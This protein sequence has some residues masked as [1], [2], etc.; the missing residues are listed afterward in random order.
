MLSS[1]SPARAERVLRMAIATAIC[2]IPVVGC[3][4][5]GCSGGGEKFDV[6]FTPCAADAGTDADG[7]ACP[8]TCLEACRDLEPSSMVGLE[9]ICADSDAAMVALTPGIQVTVHCEAVKN[10]TGRKLDGIAAPL[11]PGEPPGAWLARAAWLEAS[12]IFAFRRLARELRAHGA[13]RALVKAARACA[14]DEIRHARAMGALAKKYGVAIPR[15][16]LGALPVRDLEAIARENAVEGCVSE[17]YGAAV[18]AWQGTCASDPDVARVMR[19]IAP[20]ELRHAALGWAV[21]A[22]ITRRLS[23]DARERV[24]LARDEATRALLEE[25]RHAREEHALATALAEQLWAA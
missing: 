11:I 5:L 1:S 14:R 6:S 12:A 23:N 4:G 21:D 20:D 25:T 15:V 18:A 8:T 2:S 3:I 19:E 17:T 22:W 24:R 10:C 9:G 7:G 13:P 16:S